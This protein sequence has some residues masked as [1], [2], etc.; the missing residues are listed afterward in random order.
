MK[1]LIGILFFFI[2]VSVFAQNPQLDNAG[3]TLYSNL[4]NTYYID[5]SSYVTPG[6]YQVGWGSGYIDL[7]VLTY[8][9]DDY[10]DANGYQC[11]ARSNSSILRF[12]PDAVGLPGTFT[13]YTLPY[14]VTDIFG[15]PS[16]I[17]YLYIKIYW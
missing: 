8:A 17:A 4:S 1:K 15:N 6:Q 7:F 12:Q 3:V 16:N 11:N 10:V 9:L 13:K 14:Y 2:S 5:Y